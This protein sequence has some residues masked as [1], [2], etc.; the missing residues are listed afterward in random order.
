M[1]ALIK[2]LTLISIF[3]LFGCEEKKTSTVAAQKA[4]IEAAKNKQLESEVEQLK[5]EKTEL[6][7]EL[8]RLTTAEQEAKTRVSP[9]QRDQIVKLL[10][11]GSRE[12]SA[13]T[14]GVSLQNFRILHADFNGAVELVVANWPKNISLELKKKLEDAAKCWSFSQEVWG[15][16]IQYEKD[17]NGFFVSDTPI[18][19][20]LKAFIKTHEYQSPNGKNLEQAPWGSLRIGLTVGSSLFESFRAEM[21]TELNK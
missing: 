5:S 3:I 9:F 21:L 13:T 10:E 1:N 14:A 17:F 18:P 15:D 12:N 6:Q 2:Y 19:E 20:P 8:T 16:K 11:S 4:E 7:R